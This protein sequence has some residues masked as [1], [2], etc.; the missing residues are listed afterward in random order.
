MRISKLF[1]LY[2]ALFLAPLLA[3]AQGESASYQLRWH[4]ADDNSLPQNSVKSIIQ[5]KH[6]FIWLSTENGLV[7]YDGHHFKVFGIDSEIGINSNRIYS[8]RGSVQKDSI[9]VQDDARD[10]ILIKGSDASVMPENRVPEHFRIVNV[11][12]EGTQNYIDKLHLP[13]NSYYT[14]Y[15]QKISYYSQQN[16]LMWQA[17]YPYGDLTKS[18]FSL[19]GSLYHFDGS[20]VVRFDR[21]KPALEKVSGL[22]G[23]SAELIANNVSHQAFFRIGADLF[24]LQNKKGGLALKPV[25][26]GLDISHYNIVSAYYDAANDILYLGSSTNGLLIVKKKLFKILPG[27]NDNGVYYALTPFGNDRFLTASGEIFAPSGTLRGNLFKSPNDKYA[28]LIDRHGDIWTKA[29]NIVYRYRKET[30]FS[31]SDRWV[32]SDRVTQLFE[33]RDGQIVVGMSIIGSEKGKIYHLQP[34]GKKPGFVWLMDVDFNPTYMSQSED[35]VIWTGSQLGLHK[36]YFRERRTEPVPAISETYVRSIY[37]SGN[38][39]VWV[40]TYDRGFFLHNPATGK[41]TSF[42]VDKNRYLLSAHCIVE[43]RNGF[44]W[45][46]TNKGLFQVLKKNLVDYS[47]G[48]ASSIYYQYYDK[49]DGFATNEFNGGCQ[50]C[51]L[52]LGNSL[53]AFPS[54]KGY[55]LFDSSEVRMLMPSSDIFFG[56]AESDNQKVAIRGGRLTLNQGFGR[57]KVSIY[58]PYFGNPNNLNIETRLE[59]P[60]SQ[61]WSRLSTDEISFTAL[62]PGTYYLDVRKMTGFDSQYRNKRLVIEIQPA[63]Y[64]TWWFRIL[65]A[66]LVLLAMGY[67]VKMRMRYIRRKNILLEKKVAE[68]TFQLRSTVTALR[69]TKQNLGKE[70]VK[71]KKLIA[72]IT[73]DIK[74]PLRFLA[75]TGKHAYTSGDLSAEVSEDLRLIY[76]SSYQL[77]NFVDNLLEYSKVSEEQNLSAPFNLWQLAEEKIEMFRNLASSQR[78]EITNLIEK[79]QAV[80]TSRLLLSIVIHNLLDNAVKNTFGGTITLASFQ[81]Q[82]NFFIEISDT[83]RGM[84]AQQAGFYSTP[85]EE[86]SEEGVRK[87]GMGLPMVNE[88]MDILNGSMQIKSS[89]GKGTTVTLVFPLDSRSNQFS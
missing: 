27:S 5:D 89:L 12:V 86:R 72:A 10:Y 9:Y 24:L 83:G 67:A 4:S 13:D 75:M 47:L 40:T 49:S 14:F 2:H 71:H 50:P 59:G 33:M 88:L 61:R 21:G 17:G 38:D 36:L 56:E 41:T 81:T 39:Q 15:K 29:H 19:S 43:D 16:T 79:N 25:L 60:V 70:V 6:G 85:S 18:F 48:R 20:E 54:M 11:F 78:T 58:R 84:T 68:K 82:K 87:I 51:G 76:T 55:V 62:P 31:S 34:R 73:H 45:I 80:T 8:F 52:L 53:I 32:F 30:G 35:G 64:Q 22:S 3:F 63:F 23:S 1:F 42:P 46:S 74:S 28:V 66:A 57:L 37:L 26:E 7:R 69:R 65:T 77:Y 44:F